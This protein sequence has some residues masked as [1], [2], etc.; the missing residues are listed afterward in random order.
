MASRKLKNV[1][2]RELVKEVNRGGQAAA[3]SKRNVSTSTIS[4]ILKAN[5]F[6]P[7]IVYVRKGEGEKAS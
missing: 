1:D 4:R 7:R 5:G 6:E 3:A 2:V